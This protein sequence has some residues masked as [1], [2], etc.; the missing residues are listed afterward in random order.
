MFTSPYLPGSI[1]ETCFASS[2]LA[3]FVSGKVKLSLFLINQT[4]RH[5]NVW[6]SGCI[7]PHVLGHGTDW[8]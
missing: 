3:L 4:L 1:P 8:K 6:E 2:A 7:D 5:E